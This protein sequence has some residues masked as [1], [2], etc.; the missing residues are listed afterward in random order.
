MPDY[1]YDAAAELAAAPE[2]TDDQLADIADALRRNAHF[3]D[4]R[5]LIRLPQWQVHGETITIE[6]T[7]CPMGFIAIPYGT[8]ALDGDRDW[9]ID[10]VRD[11]IRD[12]VPRRSGY[13][14]FMVD[15][16]PEDFDW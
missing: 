11:Y 10:L 8:L 1:N 16:D 6:R 12:E 2:P 13:G 5:M 9:D 3:T 4:Q 7:S 14:D 15:A